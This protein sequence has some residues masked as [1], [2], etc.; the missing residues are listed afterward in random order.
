MTDLRYAGRKEKRTRFSAEE[1][2]EFAISEAQDADVYRK[3]TQGAIKWYL[4]LIRDLA[5]TKM[6][7]N[8]FK[9]GSRIKTGWKPGHLYFFGYDAK[10]K[11]SK[12]KDGRP[13]LPYWDKFPL[14]FPIEP[15]KNKNGSAGFYGLNLHY[16]PLAYRARFLSVLYKTMNNRNYNDSTRLRLSYDW[17][18]NGLS[19]WNKAAA[20]LCF[21]E[22]LFGHIKTQF[23][24]IM[25][26][27][28]P[29]AMYLPM[30]QWQKQGFNAVYFDITAKLK[31]Q[32]KL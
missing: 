30:E 20:S 24:H 16:I 7:R 3:H 5:P 8:S 21:K 9:D 13:V 19:G 28:W 17:L 15:V 4:G 10:H 23:I 29:V 12:L 31:T 27:E 18:K 14:V 25:P 1:M 32:S 26:D 6:N 22:Y 11:D 2:F